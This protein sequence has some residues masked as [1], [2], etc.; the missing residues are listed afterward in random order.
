[1]PVR[2]CARGWQKV[3]QKKKKKSKGL[4]GSK[5]PWN[6]IYCYKS[7]GEENTFSINYFFFTWRPISATKGY[8]K[9]KKIIKKIIWSINVGNYNV[10]IINLLIVVLIN[11][12]FGSQ[13]TTMSVLLFKFPPLIKYLIIVF[14]FKEKDKREIRIVLR[15]RNI[16]FL[17]WLHL[18]SLAMSLLF[19]YVWFNFKCIYVRLCLFYSPVVVK[20]SFSLAFGGLH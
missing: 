11:W 17:P 2:R 6:I 16:S 19:V 12:C 8:K 3:L 13:L 18:F 14:F 9:F 15:T 10:T 1:M 5:T 7:T 20:L 4:L